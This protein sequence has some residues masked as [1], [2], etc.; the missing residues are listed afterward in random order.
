MYS[1]DVDVLRVEICVE[2]VTEIHT[3]STHISPHISLREKKLC[4]RGDMHEIL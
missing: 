2:D 3:S 4:E 1:S